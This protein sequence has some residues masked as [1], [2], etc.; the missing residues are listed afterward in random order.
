MSSKGRKARDQER[1]VVFKIVLAAVACIFAVV[2]I[3]ILLRNGSLLIKDAGKRSDES[4]S[5]EEVWVPEIESKGADDVEQV[6][7]P[8]YEPNVADSADFTKKSGEDFVE[9]FGES[10]NL[11]KETA[12]P[13]G[14]L[15]EPE[16]FDEE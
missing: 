12:P 14:N 4:P 3:V 16:D 8:K 10:E 1:A 5:A 2:L 6:T 9:V 7:A 15:F 11:A 13:D